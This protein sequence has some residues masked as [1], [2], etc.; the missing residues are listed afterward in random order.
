MLPRLAADV[1][2]VDLDLAGDLVEAPGLHGEPDAVQHEP[3]RLLRDAER[4]AEFVGADPVL[5][6]GDE[7][8]GGEPLVEAERRVLEDRPDLDGVLLLA[9]LALPEPPRVR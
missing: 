8:D 3:C 5:A 7:P 4:A 9:G 6:V 2:L 1:G